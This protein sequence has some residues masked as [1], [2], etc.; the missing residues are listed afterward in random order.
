MRILRVL[1]R[2]EGPGAHGITGARI[3]RG[4]IVQVADGRAFRLGIHERGLSIRELLVG[5]EQVRH[6]LLQVVQCIHKYLLLLK[7]ISQLVG[8]IA[9]PSDLLLLLG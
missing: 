5:R 8:E 2:R 1:S 3:V 4:L 6:L 7:L 9:H